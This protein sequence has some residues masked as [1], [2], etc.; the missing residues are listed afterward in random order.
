MRLPLDH[1]LVTV[2]ARRGW[3]DLR[4]WSGRRA[5][6]RPDAAARELPVHVRRRLTGR[7]RAPVS[8]ADL[9]LVAAASAL[10]AATLVLHDLPGSGTL[11][12]EASPVTVIGAVLLLAA[13][14]RMPGAVAGVVAGTVLYAAAG[15][16]GS[17]SSGDEAYGLWA[18]LAT[19]V[20]TAALAI[21]VAWQVERRSHWNAMLRLTRENL[22]MAVQIEEVLQASEERFRA[23]VRHASDVMLILHADGTGRYVSASVQHVLGYRPEELL[24][25]EIFALVHPDDA[26]DVLNRYVERLGSAG[27]GP[28]FAARCRHRDGSWRYL[29]C[30]INNQL[31]DPYV[32]GIILNARDITE[33]KRAEAELRESE[34][35]FRGL[36]ENVPL[37]IFRLAPDGRL[38]LANPMLVQMLGYASFDELTQDEGLQEGFGRDTLAAALRS[39]AVRGAE[40]EW[41][42]R[43][44]AR[45]RL[46]LSAQ[47]VADDQGHVRYYEGT[48]EDITEQRRL[49]AR[50]SQAERLSALGELAAGMAHEVNNPLAAV[51]ATA[52]LALRGELT[53][54]L[55]DDLTVIHREASRAGEIVRS[56]LRFARQREPSLAPV[57][58]ESI[59]E[60]ALSLRADRLNRYRIAVMREYAPA[61]DI[62][63]DRDQLLQVLINL[64]NNSIDAMKPQGGGQITVRICP[65]EGGVELTLTD[66][67]PG[68]PADV[69]DR[70]FD[71]FVTTKPPGEG[72]GLGLSVSHRIVQEHRGT[73]TAE[74]LPGGGACF[75]I[76]LPTLAPGQSSESLRDG[77]RALIAVADPMA[78]DLLTEAARLLGFEPQPPAA[79]CDLAGVA[80]AV[81]D[82]NVPDDLLIRLRSGRPAP[83]LIAA[84]PPPAGSPPIWDAI[85]TPPYR[86]HDLRTALEGVCDDDA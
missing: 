82:P 84:A 33:R 29:E 11:G 23:L 36:F 69:L 78:A 39:G 41:T 32:G 83:R 68:I 75:R 71:P 7:A 57:Q 56:M 13:R 53:P 17:G 59:A 22:A 5:G 79:A 46:R 16:A 86:I 45:L 2:S 19:A 60:E 20:L 54:Q 15:L 42:R 27:A 67:G 76:C 55:R 4:R 72:T 43:D 6:L 21:G 73:L 44:G 26:A 81:V 34:E 25:V 74:N 66:S 9:V 8:L 49:A 52:E 10:L 12:H 64:I 85:L 50:L 31:D 14:W 48:L 35:R 28:P 1:P 80:V 51:A 38:L 61:P 18:H 37:G 30:I 65:L 58:L 40:L 63:A 70:I 77:R 47:A 3:L 24:G 62:M